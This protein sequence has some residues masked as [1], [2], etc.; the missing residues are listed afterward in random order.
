MHKTIL[1]TDKPCV[2]EAEMGETSG[3]GSGWSH[4]AFSLVFSPQTPQKPDWVLCAVETRY[5]FM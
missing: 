2:S 5:I 4:V 3:R 1:Q